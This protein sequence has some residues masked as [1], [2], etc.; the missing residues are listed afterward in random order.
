M[1]II[2]KKF[3]G[4]S[5]SS[6][7]RIERAVS[8]IKKSRKQGFKVVIVVSAM[9]KETDRL[10]N[11][12]SDLDIYEKSDDI[13]TLLSSGEQ[14]SSA[15]FSI[16]LNKNNIK[17]KSFQGWQLPI[18]TSETITNSQIL[19]ID[20]SSIRKSLKNNEVPVISG[21]QGVNKFNRITT[22]G[23]G[24]S[25]TT[26]VALAASLKA[27]RCD[28]YTDVDGVYSA[29]PRIVKEAKKINEINYEEMLEL[30]SLGA[31]VLH[32]R[33]VQLALK[34]NI[35]LQV[36][37]SFTGKKGTMLKKK[38]VNLEKQIIRGIAHS[39][40]E[41]LITLI[42]I[43]NTPGISAVIFSALSK[44]N[45]NVDMIVQSG[46][47]TDARVTY[48]FTVLKSDA[49]KT[50]TIMS[51]LEKKLKFTDIFINNKICK[52]SIVG[53]GMKTNA[54]V[55]NSMFSE[56]AKNNINIHVISTSE[57]KISVLIDDK[58]KELA[59][60]AL[61]TIFKLNAKKK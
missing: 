52:V 10:L 13:A 56:L 43:E 55:A 46:S 2:I 17:G 30:S 4:T 20:T 18:K 41:T 47:A 57:I 61:H 34:Y 12:T 25:D 11:L 8:Y 33:S 27:K 53:L 45:I 23:R 22:L 24:G 51:N 15:L 32:T 49:E 21:F 35:N 39:S 14:I 58:Y 54:G 42:D 37:S 31:K 29:D 9:G 48:S 19:Q 26:A 3:G 28:I 60:R 38:N 16:I 36:L 1:N 7:E 44:E 59:I 6:L 40:N 50:K 5:V